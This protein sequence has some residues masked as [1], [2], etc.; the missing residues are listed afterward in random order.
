LMKFQTA[1]NLFLV[2]FVLYRLKGHGVMR[3]LGSAFIRQNSAR[4]DRADI[5]HRHDTVQFGDAWVHDCL[6][7]AVK[8]SREAFQQ[9]GISRQARA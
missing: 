2:S 7:V 4:D 5:H 9:F 8:I 6:C 3:K 1:G